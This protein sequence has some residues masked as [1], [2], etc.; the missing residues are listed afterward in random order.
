MNSRA[1]QRF[2]ST[3]KE[4]RHCSARLVY[5]L[6]RS[7][8]I[9]R[10][11]EN[12]PFRLVI[13]GA[14]GL[15]GQILT[16]QAL[17]QNCRVTAV[18]RRP[19]AYTQHHDR[20]R[21]VQGDVY[22]ERS[23][24]AAI[25]NQDVVI[26]L[27]AVPY[28]LNS[29]SIYS[30]SARTIVLAMQAAGVRRLLFTTSGGTRPGYDPAE[31]FIFGRIIKPSIGRSTYEDMRKAEEITMSSDLD[32]TIVRPQR[33]MNNAAFKRYQSQEGYYVSEK[34]I[35]TRAHLADFLMREIIEGQYISNHLSTDQGYFCS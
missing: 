30:Q 17:E 19:E 22:D 10:A 2:T 12:H 20:L 18:T 23:V 9:L 25:Q 6:Q 34:R 35:T 7:G 15:T 31:D 27:V 21:V 33:L 24:L 13:F 14:S 29:V 26:S 3:V 16:R 8:F 32:W 28:T 4:D 1:G 11:M 5:N